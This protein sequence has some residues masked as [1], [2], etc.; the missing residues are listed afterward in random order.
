MFIFPIVPQVLD[1]QILEF[2]TVM[3]DVQLEIGIDDYIDVLIWSFY[4]LPNFTL[5]LSDGQSI[6]LSE[7]TDLQSVF[8]NEKLVQITLLGMSSI[9]WTN[10]LG[11][12]EN[13]YDL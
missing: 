7:E 8:K 11:I 2:I 3:C 12:V 4:S 6:R 5:L 9:L 10:V 1:I 13:V